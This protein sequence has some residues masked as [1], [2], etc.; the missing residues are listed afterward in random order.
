MDSTECR[1]YS[2]STR[3]PCDS[4]STTQSQSEQ[5]YKSQGNGLTTDYVSSLPEEPYTDFIKITYLT[6]LLCEDSSSHR[7]DKFRKTYEDNAFLISVPIKEPV[8]QATLRFWDP[9][10]RCFT[11]G[12]KD[13]VPTIEE[14][15]EGADFRH[16]DKVYNKKSRAGCRKMLAKI[17]KVKPQM[18]DTYLVQKE[19]HKGLPWNILWDFI[20][21]HLHDEDGVVAF[22]LSVYGLI[23]FPGMLGYIEMAVVDTFEHIQYG[24]NLSLVILAET[25][26]SLNY[27][28]R[29]QE[30]RF[31]RFAPLLY[32][33]IRSH[34]MCEGITFTKSYFPRAAPIIEFN[35]N[36]WPQ[37]ETKE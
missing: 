29:N 31:L 8:L 35:Q 34:I 33:Q 5:I 22:A 1:V 19:N 32:I 18:I 27:C 20:R 14:Y 16:L 23:I 26:R 11:F 30:G 28:R 24:N 13:L 36:T 7:K 2:S 25:F 4:Y 3:L 12:K 6:Q 21:R 37:P 10:Y 15:S 17:L 9:S